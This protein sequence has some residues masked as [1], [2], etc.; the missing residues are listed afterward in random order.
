MDATEIKSA[1]EATTSQFK[2][3]L[4]T[5]SQEIKQ[6]GE[7]SAATAKQIK[8]V[9]ATLESLAGDIKSIDEKNQERIDE[10]EAKSNRLMSGE[11]EAKKSMGDQFIDSDAYA[12]M[13]S[14]SEDRRVGKE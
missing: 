2:E 10:L 5:Q 14:R 13:K 4:D 7:T 12:E 6:F 1:L 9:E 11:F 3:L 8:S